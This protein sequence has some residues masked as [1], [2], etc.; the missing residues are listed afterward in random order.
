MFLLLYQTPGLYLA[1]KWLLCTNSLS[2]LNEVNV[3]VPTY[4]LTQFFTLSIQ[5]SEYTLGFVRTLNSEAKAD[6]VCFITTA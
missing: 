4:L 5:L 6:F 1:F 3:R 2:T